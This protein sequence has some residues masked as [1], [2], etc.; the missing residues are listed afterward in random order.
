MLNY[1]E[2]FCTVIKEGSISAAAKVMHLT[3]PALSSQIQSLEQHFGVKLLERTNKGVIPTPAGEKVFYY[4]QR[5]STLCENMHQ[6]VERIKSSGEGEIVIGAS[7]T[8]GGY[9][10]PCSIYIFKEKYPDADI[11]V[12]VS[13]TEEVFQ[14]LV[15]RS[16]QMGIVEGP[17]QRKGVT[18]HAIT[19]DELLLIAPNAKPWTSKKSVT[20]EELT[21]LPF[22]L[23]EQGSGIRNTIEKALAKHG[24]RLDDLNIVMELNDIDAIKASVEAERGV[25]LLPRLAVKKELWTKTLTGFKVE[26]VTFRHYFYVIYLQGREIIGLE[27]QFLDFIQSKDRGFC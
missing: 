22:I 14:K 2:A 10:L 18:S 24:I 20:L 19:Y 9:A 8:V 3:Q 7:S 17:V 23:R 21:T 15:D 1:L 26:G 16:I 11:K 4:A 5:I 6:E 12:L 25:T 13:N 27:R